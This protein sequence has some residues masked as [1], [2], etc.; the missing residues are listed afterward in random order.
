VVSAMDPHGRIVGYLD[1]GKNS[2]TLQNYEKVR[3]IRI[4]GKNN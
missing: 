4:F 3:N 2:I 1:R